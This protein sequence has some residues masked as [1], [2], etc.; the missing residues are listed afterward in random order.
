MVS[1]VKSFADMQKYGGKPTTFYD[2][3]MLTV[4]WETKPE[5]IERLLPKPLKPTSR[6]LVNAFIANYPATNFCPPYRE[7]GLFVL[8][9]YNGQLGNYCL[10][11]PIT[12]DIGM[13]MGREVCGLPKKMADVR[14]HTS[15][16]GIDGAIGRHGIDFFNVKATMDGHFNDNGAEKI[17]E[18]YYGKDIP[19]Y[20]IKYANA[21]DGNG[22][23]LMPTL[24]TQRLVSEVKVY[25]AAEASITFQDSPHDPWSELEV[26]NM[27]G[28]VYTVSTNV[29]EKGKI[30]EPLN[31]MEY[32]PYC[33]LRWDWWENN[34]QPVSSV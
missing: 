33:Y 5:I 2:A 18:E 29:L 23:D 9:D 7:A 28:A 8:A 32:L 4:Y 20:N 24:V 16:D 14:M 34:L 10:S 26:V 21:I 25:K 31:P 17:L 19:L 13:A 1:F 27:L 11:M 6:P 30:L 15:E 22:F 3:E 12:S